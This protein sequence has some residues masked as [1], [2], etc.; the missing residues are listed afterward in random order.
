[1]VTAP[2]M[3][4]ARK[5]AAALLKERQAAC[6]NL[7]PKV[8]SHYWWQ[9]TLESSS[10]VLVLI[11]TAMSKLDQLEKTVREYH[12]YDTPEIIAIKLDQGN[13]RYLEWIAAS[14]KTNK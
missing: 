14:V 7:V 11:K 5:L 6:V 4:C 8:E 2:N 12:P 9:G 13:A 10:E 3:N 1:M